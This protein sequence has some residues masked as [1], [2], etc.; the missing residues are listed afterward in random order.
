[1]NGQPLRYLSLFSGI[2]GFD[3]GFD[4][5]GMVCAG[6]V[7]FDEK[8]RA[9]LAKHWPDVPRLND[10]R[11]VNGDEFG[12]IDL[13]CGGFP[14]QDVSVAGRRAGLAGERSGTVA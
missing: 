8:A 7:E 1:M 12:S 6:Q 5:A 11:E 14:C 3:L 13:I 2:G 4:R 10:V 9:V